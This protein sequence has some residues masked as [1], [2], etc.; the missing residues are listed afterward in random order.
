MLSIAGLCQCVVDICVWPAFIMTKTK[1]KHTT[2]R[3]VGSKP[4]QHAN[5]DA[6]I[7]HN[8]VK[9]LVE[10]D[11]RSVVTNKMLK[12]LHLKKKEKR[13]VKH[14][15]WKKR[16]NTAVEARSNALKTKRRKNIDNVV[17]DMSA[18]LESLPFEELINKMSSKTNSQQNAKK[19]SFRKET[20][21][22]QEKLSDIS[23]FRSILYHPLFKSNPIETVTEHLRK[24]LDSDVN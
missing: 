13:K 4:S 21:R 10:D 11:A 5:S 7:V 6:D 24:Q 9:N 3:H 17:G 20:V 16:V 22:Q 8:Q 2:A 15:L 1:K 12:D 19:K 18:M 14:T 23:L